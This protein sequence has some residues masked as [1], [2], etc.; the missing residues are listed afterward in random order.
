MVYVR[1]SIVILLFG[2]VW[3][4]NGGVK[5][6]NDMAEERK[7]GERKEVL[8]GAWAEGGE[9]GVGMEDAEVA[10]HFLYLSR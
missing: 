5:V 3:W 1:F 8:L 7:E 2:G 10:V 4:Y 9:G 6:L